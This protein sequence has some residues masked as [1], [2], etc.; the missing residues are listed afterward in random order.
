[1]AAVPDQLGAQAVKVPQYVLESET[2]FHEVCILL[3]YR[4]CA[5]WYI[6]WYSAYYVYEM[7]TVYSM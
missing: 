3:G 6:V 2:H 5:V 4:M 7:Y 1:M